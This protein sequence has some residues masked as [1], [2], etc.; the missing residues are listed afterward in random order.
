MSSHWKRSRAAARTASAPA[1]LVGSRVDSQ[2]AV[3]MPMLEEHRIAVHVNA[4]R[5]AS[6]AACAAGDAL[7]INE[8][9]T[10]WRRAAFA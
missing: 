1:E 4:M 2:G 9:R 3:R 7:M 6:A 5:F 8:A 10:S